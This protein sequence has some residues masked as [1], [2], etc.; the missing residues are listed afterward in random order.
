M[1]E[2]DREQ[3]V[4]FLMRF[5]A[6]E[7]TT[8]NERAIGEE[9]AAALRELGVPAD[10]IRFDG[11]ERRIPVPTET[12]NL[13]VHVPGDPSLPLRMFS[14][15]RDTVPLCAGAMPRLE[16]DRIVPAGPTALGGDD[17]TGVACLVTMLA[18]LL[19]S[20]ARH[21]PLVLVFT[22]REE[23]GLWGAR[24]LDVAMVGKPALAFNVDGSSAQVL[25]VGAVGAAHW[26]V[27]ITGKAAH[28][29][30][31]PEEGV[32]AP[33]VA[34]VALATLQRRGWFGK[35]SRGSGGTS[36]LGALLGR[37]GGRVGG[38]TNVVTDFVRVE[39][40]ARSHDGRF[41]PKIVGA[42]RR[43]FEAA[44]AKL[45]SALGVAAQVAFDSRVQYHPFRLDPESEVVAFARERVK[46]LGMT[47]EL[48]ISDGGLD[49]NW[50]A[51]HGIPA[52]TFGAGQ[53][54]IH[55][56]EEHVILDDY[57]SACRLAVALAGA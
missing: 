9:I 6:V 17:R 28:A 36:N 19:R 11:A 52:V 16:G 26:S 55:S 20:G 4:A 50:L 54:A 39:G 2:I 13:I 7:G 25:T 53:R 24:H 44:A 48:R 10:A 37:D 1:P 22:V 38:P 5:L 29:G 42:Y 34:S 56:V 23:S 32:S 41:V 12:G 27:E 8:G 40:E 15:H 35:I 3:A 14:A 31:H 47:P 18:T 33:M 49:A 43:A 30:L 57:L 21:P 46:S 45:P 51:K